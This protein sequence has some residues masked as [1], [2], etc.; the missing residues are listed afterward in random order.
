M[1]RNTLTIRV[2]IHSFSCYCLRNTRYVAK[3]PREFDFTAVQGH[4]RSL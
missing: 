2:C 4:P 1:G 3:I